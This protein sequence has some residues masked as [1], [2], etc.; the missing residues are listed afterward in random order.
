MGGV[1]VKMPSRPSLQR[2]IGLKEGDEVMF[3]H[4]Y[5]VASCGFTRRR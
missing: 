2:Y 4:R 3:L 5:T 1:L